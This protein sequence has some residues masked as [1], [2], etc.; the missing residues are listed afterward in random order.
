MYGVILT[1]H[2]EYSKGVYS[3]L[4]LVIGEMDNIR[5]VDYL[6]SQSYED[7]DKNLKATYDELSKKYEKIIFIT[8]LLG[9]TPFSRSVLNFG[10][11]KFVRVLTG[12][13]FPLV[14]SALIKEDTEDM[15]ADVK[16]IIDDGQNGITF[17]QKPAEN[18]QEETDG[19]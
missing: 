18:K 13:N 12:M 19:I 5:V 4:K 15:D 14:Y 1:A 6:E 17:Y 16:S 7:L 2:S 10:A 9:G 8:D 11:N 3:G